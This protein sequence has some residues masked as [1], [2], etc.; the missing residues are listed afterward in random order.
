MKILLTGAKGQLGLVAAAH[1]ASEGCEVVPLA[2]RDLDIT[3]H[4]AVCG[5]VSSERPDAVVNCAAYN[6]VDGAE[7][8]AVAALSVNSFAVRSL[9]RAAAESGAVLVHYGTDFVFDGETDRPYTEED[10]PRPLGVYAASKLLGEWFAAD[11]PRH[12]V[13]R[14]ESLFGGAAEENFRGKSSVDRIIDALSA[15]GEARAFSD[16][17]VSPSYVLDV[18]RATWFLVRE[19]A[20]AGLYHCVNTGCTTWYDLACEV[21]RLVGSGVPVPV[22]VDDVRLRAPRPRFAALDNSKLRAAGFVMPAWQDAVARHVAARKG[23]G[24]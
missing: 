16:R 15:G 20:P 19:G 6:D 17:V 24:R 1:F 2:M 22:S 10:A 18:A 7:E 5:R 14:V 4:R 3:D 11:A 23:I 9:A 21:A 8:N 12:Y 13:L